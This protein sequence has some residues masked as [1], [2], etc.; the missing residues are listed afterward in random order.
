MPG[1][2][3]ELIQVEDLCERLCLDPLADAILPPALAGLLERVRQVEI[4]RLAAM[5]AWLS[6]DPPDTR[7]QEA[8]IAARDAASRGKAAFADAYN[9]W[10]AAQDPASRC[11]HCGYY[12]L[13]GVCAECACTTETRRH[14][15]ITEEEEEPWNS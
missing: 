15:A 3:I 8:W 11:R 7:I 12:A 6:A 1:P 9:R 14:G 5:D 10:S 4:D 2:L 13:G